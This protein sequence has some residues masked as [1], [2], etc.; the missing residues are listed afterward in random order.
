VETLAREVEWKAQEVSNDVVQW[1]GSKTSDWE[2]TPP[3]SPVD[4][5]WPGAVMDE[6]CGTWPSSSEVVPTHADGWPNLSADI[7]GG[8]EVTIEVSSSIG[9]SQG[10]H[11]ACR[12]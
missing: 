11:A 5:G 7:T 9:E 8:I 3:A 10:E 1:G 12:F 6:H 2:V 4:G